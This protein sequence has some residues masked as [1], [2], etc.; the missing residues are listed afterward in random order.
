MGGERQLHGRWWEGRDNGRGVAATWEMVDGSG[1][2]GTMG[3]RG[4]TV[5]WEMVGGEVLWEGTERQLHGRWWEG[6]D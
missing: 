2:G 4:E 6:R 1:R 5:T 3:G